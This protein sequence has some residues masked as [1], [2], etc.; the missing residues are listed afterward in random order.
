M[1]YRF[2][3]YDGQPLS[4]RPSVNEGR[5][6]CAKCGFVHYPNPKPCVAVLVERDGKVLL[7][8]R[9]IEPAKGK[10]DIP[11]GFLEWGE[12]AEEAAIR[13]CREELNVQVRIIDLL[14]TISDIYGPQKIP[15]LNLCFLAEI[16][17]G[18]PN[19]ASDVE[20]LAWFGAHE[21][22]KDLSFRHQKEALWWWANRAGRAVTR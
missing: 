22:P 19:A 6:W 3:P 16:V 4:V 9:R 2:C 13:E 17:E 14:G 18:K 15:T 5:P 20:A 21:F 12:S 10:W 11:G 1:D 8:R 7:A